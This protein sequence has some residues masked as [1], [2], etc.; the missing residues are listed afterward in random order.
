MPALDPASSVRMTTDVSSTGEFNRA[1][2]LAKLM[3]HSKSPVPPECQFSIEACIDRVCK[4]T[5]RARDSA[6]G[7]RFWSNYTVTLARNGALPGATLNFAIATLFKDSLCKGPPH[8]RQPTLVATPA[9]RHVPAPALK[10]AIS[11]CARTQTSERDWW[12]V[13]GLVLASVAAIVVIRAVELTHPHTV[14]AAEATIQSLFM[15][16]GVKPEPTTLFYENPYRTYPPDG[17]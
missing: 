11:A 10:P 12:V 7:G 3:M 15:W 5:P 14:P 6:I 4:D 17:A 8:A 13:G 16:M 2:E 1:V 9:A